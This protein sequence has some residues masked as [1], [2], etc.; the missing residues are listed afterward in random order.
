[1]WWTPARYIK[2][3]KLQVFNFHSPRQ[4]LPPKGKR[5]NLLLSGR[6][7]LVLFFMLLIF[8]G[9]ARPIT[10]PDFWWHLRTGQFIVETHTIPHA[11]IFS[12]LRFGSEWVTH[13]WLSEV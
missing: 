12:A 13:E 6:R 9:A 5:V 2:V 11:D 8:A 4:F 1:M 3:G 7:L 10:D